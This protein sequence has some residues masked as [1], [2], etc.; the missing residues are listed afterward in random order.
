[1]DPELKKIIDEILER[2]EK[3]LEAQENIRTR[4]ANLERLE[5][6][7]HTPLDVVA[8]QRLPGR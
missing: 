8:R 2:L 7:S 6:R 1:M 3:I 4:L 5:S